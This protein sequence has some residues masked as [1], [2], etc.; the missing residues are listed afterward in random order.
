MIFFLKKRSIENPIQHRVREYNARQ[1]NIDLVSTTVKLARDFVNSIRAKEEEARYHTEEELDNLTSITEKVEKWMAEQ[2]EAQ[3]KL[4]ET[5]NPVI[6][7]S[8]V[9][10]KVKS[11]EENLMKLLSKKKPKKVQVKKEPET[12]EKTEEESSKEDTQQE[13]PPVHTETPTSEEHEHDEL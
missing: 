13:A 5:E 1:G 4:A 10:E 8:K 9:S 6:V 2:V 12:T 11:I 7:T 3:K